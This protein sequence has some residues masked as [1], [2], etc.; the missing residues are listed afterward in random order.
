MAEG[1]IECR[2]I[3]TAGTFRMWGYWA[4]AVAVLASTLQPYTFPNA[5]PAD[6]TSVDTTVTGAPTFQLQRSGTGVWT[7]MTTNLL[8]EALN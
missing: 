7:A 2:A 3:G 6:V 1:Y 4:P 5:T 8:F